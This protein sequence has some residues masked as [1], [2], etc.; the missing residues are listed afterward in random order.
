MEVFRTRSFDV[1]QQENVMKVNSDAILLGA[2]ADYS[3]SE[4]ILD[5]GTGTG[6][7]AM[8]A[9]Q[10]SDASRIVGIEISEP[11][12]KEGAENFKQ[13]IYSDRLEAIC[14]S[15]QDYA[16]FSQDKY[17]LIVSNPPFFT[18][19]TF[20]DNENRNNVRNTIRLSHGDLLIAVRKLL[21]PQG[22]FYVI[23]PY[24]EGERLIDMAARYD[25]YPS[26]ILEV[27]GKSDKPIERL[28]ISLSF[29]IS[30]DELSRSE[31]VMYEDDGS[32]TD[33][34]IKLT[35]DILTIS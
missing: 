25:L 5:I 3:G 34:Y 29:Q 17:D 23:L 11:C 13:S 22:R 33:A 1:V 27:R 14:E 24:L 12:C 16:Q 21:S 35:E 20:S 9:A 4:N 18:G 10:K 31:L 6:I 32:Y 28:V 15:I 2:W 8:I 19:G 30:S 26:S 7:I